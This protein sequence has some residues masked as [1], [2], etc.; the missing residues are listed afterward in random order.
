[1]QV[2]RLVFA[3]S[4]DFFSNEQE[5]KQKYIHVHVS[6]GQRELRR[7]LLIVAISSKQ[8]KIHQLQGRMGARHG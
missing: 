7:N 1:M 4:T 6:N 5:G 2:E 3:R 8:K